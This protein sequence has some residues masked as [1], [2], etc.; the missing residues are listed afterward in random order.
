MTKTLRDF[1]RQLRVAGHTDLKGFL[2]KALTRAGLEGEKTARLAATTRLRVR[3]GRL[4]SSIT[5]TVR[6]TSNGLELVLQAGGGRRPVAYAEAQEKG[7]TIRPRRGQYLAIPLPG[8]LTAAGALK[9]RFAVPGGLRNVPGMF[10][11][12]S[13]AGNLLLVEKRGKGIAPL[14][15]LKTQTK[16]RGKAYLMSGVIAA[17]KTLPEALRQALVR[18]TR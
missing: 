3:T 6:K 4:R 17:E 1:E 10:L 11:I 9:A 8:A 12:R 13:G 7:A 14:F 5:S 18:V 15:V 16:V 2:L